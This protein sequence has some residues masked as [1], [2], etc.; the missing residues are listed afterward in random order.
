LVISLVALHNGEWRGRRV[1]DGKEVPVI[2]AYFEDTL[3][4]GD[5]KR[6]LEN[7]ARVHQGSIFLGDG[8]LLSPEE[9]DQLIQADPL[10]A[11]VI[12]PVIN[13][14]E[15]NGRPEQDPGRRIINFLDRTIESAA[16]YEEPFARLETLIKPE[17]EKR[18]TPDK[19]WQFWRPRIELHDAI[20]GSARCFGAA[21]VT[22]YLN[23]SV[24]PTGYV[25]LDT[26]YVFATDRW[27][28]YSV[29]QSSVHEVWARKYSG[30]LKQDLRYSPSDCFATFAFPARQWWTP[31][32][33]LA[34]QGESYHEHRRA[35]MR[36]LWLGL[37]KLYNLF[38]A[39]DLTP[40]LVAKV[41]K[42]PVDEAEAG[43]QGILDLRRLHRELD[44]AVRDAYGWSDLDLGHDF[45][46]VE[47]LP[48]NDRVRYTISP[49]ARKEVLRR[50]LAL[51]HERAAAEKEKTPATPAKRGRK[52]KGG[53]GQGEL[54]G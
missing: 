5:P 17:R 51:N 47:T 27:D 34:V 9:A 33:A 14:Q 31:S 32:P 1:L 52:T 35:L 41:S 42:K 8:F 53:P 46:E 45:H 7:N 23:F 29:V 19:W 10:N 48:E 12:L 20:R 26:I 21:R 6:L 11:E 39:S 15:L 4:S 50:L 30:A 36:Q 18:G 43:Y 49:E 16:N 28:L 3:D 2:S 24:L 37:T 13:G 22:K 25:F 44:E 54:F 38:H 40:A